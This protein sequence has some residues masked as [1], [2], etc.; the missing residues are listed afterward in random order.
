MKNKRPVIHALGN[1]ITKDKIEVA[2][3]FLI[4]YKTVRVENGQYFNLYGD[5]TKYELGTTYKRK[6]DKRGYWLGGKEYVSKLY[7]ARWA[8]AVGQEELL[9]KGLGVAVLECLVPLSAVTF[10]N[11]ARYRNYNL[12]ATRTMLD[13]HQS[14]GELEVNKFQPYKDVTSQ[15]VTEL[16]DYLEKIRHPVHVLPKERDTM[17]AYKGL[18]YA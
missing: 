17:R 1:T 13:A 7:F 18:D 4:L 11:H 14:H 5:K 16:Q 10:H 15:I 3:D 6:G 12:G 2:G 8:F 9:L